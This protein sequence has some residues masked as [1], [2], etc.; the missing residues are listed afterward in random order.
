[1]AGVSAAIVHEAERR[2]VLD[3]HAQH[4]SDHRQRQRIGI[5]GYDVERV[6]GRLEQL[7]GDLPHARLQRR[8]PA[9]GERLR[10]QRPQPRVH[11]RIGGVQIER[12]V[13]RLP[14]HHARRTQGLPRVPWILGQPGIGER[15]T[16]F[17]IA[18][19]EEVLESVGFGDVVHGRFLAHARVG[20]MRV[21]EEV[22]RV[23]QRGHAEPPAR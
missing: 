7:A 8:H 3:R 14:A 20:R 18:Q 15:G 13:L 22:G 9:W 5:L 19:H 23:R 17:G 16:G 11:G 6:A 4:L 21:G 12:R 2:A 10:H 1:M